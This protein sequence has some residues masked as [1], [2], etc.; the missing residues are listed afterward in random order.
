M[1]YI[2]QFSLLIH[3][4]H[5]IMTEFNLFEKILH[6]FVFSGMVIPDNPSVSETP[7]DIC[8]NYM[9]SDLDELP[10]VILSDCPSYDFIRHCK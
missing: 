9:Q 10:R 4:I 7:N 1:K 8:R 5:K 6:F 2:P 3:F